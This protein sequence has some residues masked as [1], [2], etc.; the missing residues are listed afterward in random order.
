MSTYEYS[1][2]LIVPADLRDKAQR[3]AWALGHDQP[4]LSSFRAELSADGETTTHYGLHTYA[5]QGFVDLL[6]GA[7]KGQ[8]PTIDWSEYELTEQDVA[9]VLG[10]MAVEYTV[11]TVGDTFPAAM[12]AAG[13]QRRDDG[14]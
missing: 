13:V 14:E 4:P 10:A 3:L 7:Q 2:S 9:E 8:L 5:T 12:V 1:V 6:A 11:G